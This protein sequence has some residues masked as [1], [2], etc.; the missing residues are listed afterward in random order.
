MEWGNDWSGVEGVERRSEEE[1][2]S[3]MAWHGGLSRLVS[4]SYR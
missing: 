1:G 2:V 3:G 4:Q